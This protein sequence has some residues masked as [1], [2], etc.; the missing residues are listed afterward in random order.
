MTDAKWRSISER[1]FSLNSVMLLFSLEEEI[2]KKQ[3]NT[4]I[5]VIT[6]KISIQMKT[7]STN[8]IRTH[9]ISRPCQITLSSISSMKE[10]VS[11]RPELTS[12]LTSVVSRFS[13]LL[14][15]CTLESAPPSWLSLLPDTPAIGAVR[16]T[17]GHL[18]HSEF[19]IQ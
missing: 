17:D 18:D 16:A 10:L 9:F 8:K 11:V 15:M 4:G 19:L 6:V 12:A 13:I 14:S 3:T 2:T 7:F 1:E 5:S